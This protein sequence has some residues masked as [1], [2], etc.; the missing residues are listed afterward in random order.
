MTVQSQRSFTISWRA[1]PMR[2]YVCYCAEWTG[3]GRRAAYMSF[4]NVGNSRTLNFK[5][6]G[7]ELCSRW[8]PRLTG[9]AFFFFF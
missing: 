9:M 4:Y 1:D 6:E 8:R 5:G 7:A 3:G 2:R